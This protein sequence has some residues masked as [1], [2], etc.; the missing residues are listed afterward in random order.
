MSSRVVASRAQGR[1]ETL[2]SLLAQG[3]G[4]TR[5]RELEVARRVLASDAPPVV[6]FGAGGLGRRL[7]AALGAVGARPAAF[8]DN[9]R[10]LWGT[11][12]DG[13]TVMSPADAAARYA[14]QGLFVV[15]VFNPDHAF[16]DTARQL[17][18]YGCREVI[19]WIR[20]AW[21]LESADLLPHYAAGRP[22]DVLAEAESVRSAA[23]MWADATSTAEFARQ[24]GWRLSGDLGD[25][26]DPAP[27]QYFASDLLT[28]RPGEA[29]VDCG[30]FDGD[31]LAE[32]V[33]RCPTFRT[34]D[35][36]EPD[37]VN[38]AALE[39]CSAA[40]GPLSGSVRLHQA[41]TGR[42]RGSGRF[43][44]AG[45]S[46][47]LVSA[48]ADAVQEASGELDER[49][50]PCV[51]LDDV[52]ADVPVSFIKMDVEGAEADTLRGAAGLLRRRRPA[53]AVSAY[54]HPTDLWELPKLVA[55]MTDDYRL[56]LRAH[57]PDGFDCVLYAIPAERSVQR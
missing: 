21:G 41:A 52:L 3:P 38:F 42:L 16:A 27:D 18:E 47:A 17:R 49:V 54:H 11:R 25:L 19:S 13:T 14:S 33:S 30:A 50:V 35:A 7:H 37:P 8:A 22:S 23:T 53:L 46:G 36:F 9:D 10:R 6:L 4:E 31:T 48:S 43:A 57:R 20:L 5:A 32:M 51:T 56:H 34:I 2:A 39:R 28:L 26:G 24:A 55:A 44:G 45:A 29:L 40:L 12:V 1:A 15:T